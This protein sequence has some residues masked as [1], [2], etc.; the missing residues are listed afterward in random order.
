MV[1]S[2]SLYILGS[3]TKLFLLYFLMTHFF[4]LIIVSLWSLKIIISSSDWYVYSKAFIPD[5]IRSCMSLWRVPISVSAMQFLL[6]D[7]ALKT[8]AA[9]F[10]SRAGEAYCPT[11]PSPLLYYL[12]KALCNCVCLCV[13][14][15]VQ[16]PFHTAVGIDFFLSNETPRPALPAI[17]C[18]TRLFVLCVLCWSGGRTVSALMPTDCVYVLQT[19]ISTY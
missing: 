8:S 15:W 18:H 6:Y 16:K 19:I 13:H 12:W 7:E 4:A 9:Y 11:R 5:L 3:L 10:H 2:P 14:V 17:C 1:P